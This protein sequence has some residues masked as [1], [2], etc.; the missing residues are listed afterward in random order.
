MICMFL[1]SNTSEWE[2]QIYSY[3][4]LPALILHF[5]EVTRTGE[6]FA[7]IVSFSEV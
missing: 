3:P 1:D 2:S 6:D 4:I 5:H 7:A